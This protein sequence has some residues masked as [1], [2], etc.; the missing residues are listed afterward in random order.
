MLRALIVEDEIALQELYGRILEM[1]GFD[2][3]VASDGNMAI[4]ILQQVT[5][6]LILLDIRMPNVNGREVLQYLQS[7]PDVENI[8]VVIASATV[9]F[10]NYIDMIPSAEF[11]LKPIM[12]HHLEGVVS[13][14]KNMLAS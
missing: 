9:E 14:L 6:H 7:Y 13:R 11:L 5:P 2:V 8:H 12:P 3:T 4:E 1:L 10:S